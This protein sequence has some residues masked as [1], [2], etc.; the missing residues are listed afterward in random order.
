MDICRRYGK[1]HFHVIPYRVKRPET[2]D[3]VI[4]KLYHCPQGNHEL[5]DQLQNRNIQHK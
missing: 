1:L 3:K 4:K 2:M 5:A